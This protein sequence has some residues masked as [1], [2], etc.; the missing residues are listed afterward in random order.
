MIRQKPQQRAENAKKK[1][2]FDTTIYDRQAAK[3]LKDY[4]NAVEEEKGPKKAKKSE[5]A[6]E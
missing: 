2:V 1:I 5:K 4:E 6:E 3:I